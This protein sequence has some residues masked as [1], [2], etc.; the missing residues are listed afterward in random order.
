MTLNQFASRV[1][2]CAMPIGLAPH[3]HEIGRDTLLRAEIRR[4]VHVHIVARVFT[5]VICA[6]AVAGC[7]CTTRSSTMSQTANSKKV[8]ESKKSTESQSRRPIPLPAEP[9]LS[10]QPE[11]SC[12]VESNA[13]ERQKLDYERQCY[14]H[15]EMIVR[16]RLQLLQSSVDKTISAVKRGEGGGP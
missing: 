13:D 9:L 16:S 7:A 14:R 12:E 15:A 11:P 3:E 1:R 4:R 8:T 2:D 5:V 6:I 10:P